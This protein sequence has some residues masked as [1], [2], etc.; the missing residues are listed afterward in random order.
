M[1]TTRVLC[2]SLL[3]IGVALLALSAQQ[4]TQVPVD[5][6]D[7][8]GIVS[9]SKGPEAGVWV[10]AETTGLP[11]KFSKTVVTDDRG[12][13]VIPDLPNA[14][15]SVWVRGYGLIDSAKVQST[16]GRNVNLTASLAT[17]PREA[18]KYY[19][20]GYWWSMLRP[21]DKS[22]FPGTGPQGNGISPNMTSQAAWLRQLKSGGCTAC[23]QLG[24]QA[25]R[26]IPEDLGPFPSSVAAWDRRIKSGQA[27]GNMDQGLEHTGQRT[28]PE[29]AC[30][31]DGPNRQGRSAA[32]G[33]AAPT[34]SRAQRCDHTVGLGRPE[35]LSP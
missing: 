3:M 30:R 29:S 6:N 13:Y 5:N 27:G 32:A 10:I 20:A 24:N 25:T 4:G 9:S 7:I 22:E 16:P 2:S 33:A 17:T 14:T 21:P 23:H 12:R 26:E 1:R 28:R 8:G 34:G 35:G 18:A 31:L 15:Y 11:T 19:P